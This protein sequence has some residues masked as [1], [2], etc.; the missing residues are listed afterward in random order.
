M[1]KTTTDIKTG[2]VWSIWL[3]LT[4]ITVGFVALSLGV[5]IRWV[6]DLMIFSIVVLSF[7][8]LYGYMG[9]LSFGAMLYYGT[10]AYASA[11][12]LANV[13]QNALVAIGVGLAAA[14]LSA[15]LLGGIAIRTAGAAFALI[16]MAFNEIGFFAVRSALKGWTGGDDGLS[17]NVN[18]FL[19][20]IKLHL[21]I[22]SFIFMLAM[23]LLVYFFLKTL[24][25]APYGT[26]VRAI[27]EDENRVLF[28][29][30]SALKAKWIT[31]VISS[32]LAGLAGA[33]FTVLRG[34][35][36]PDVMNP[37]ANVDMIFAVLIGGAGYLYGSLIGALVFLLIKNY[38][39]ILASEV[40]KL[41]P[42]KVPQW[43]LWL[44]IVLLIIV[45][46]WRQG[47]VGLVQVKLARRRK[48][49]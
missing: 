18:P 5:N 31:F 3:D 43:E 13:N 10:G 14:L 2:H 29:G 47:I 15:A 45:F 48:R 6:V 38:L 26:L 25:N 28:L 1:M 4:V 17:V 12:W 44:G 37:F 16:N 35:V 40:G 11:L 33:L 21:E 24:M 23:V 41:A 42:F 7:D 39:P 9:H 34:F 32:G 49:V 27:R 20:F 30:Y 22:P 19:G 46:S 36:S 8:L